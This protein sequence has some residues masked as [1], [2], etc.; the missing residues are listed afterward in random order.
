MSL[1][2]PEIPLKA[3]NGFTLIEILVVVL[4]IGITIGFALL[5]FGDFGNKR[6]I[7]MSAEHFMSYLELVEHQAILETSTFG[8]SLNQNGYQVFRFQAP[9]TWQT[10]PSRSIF[11]PRYFPENAMIRLEQ[12]ASKKGQPQIII[13]SSGEI[14]PFQLRFGLEKQPDIAIVKGN[15]N[16]TI[17][18]H[19][20]GEP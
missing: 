6:R 13:H 4:I 16:G 14:T 11:R 7:I 2:R 19:M 20:L 10:I 17:V 3:S 9:S 12:T 18:L 8:V 5:A 1:K 15:E